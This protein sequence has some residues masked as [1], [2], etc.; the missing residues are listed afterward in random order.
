MRMERWEAVGLVGLFLAGFSTLFFP[1]DQDI[2]GA[3]LAL[4]GLLAIVWGYLHRREMSVQTEGLTPSESW[5]R[6]VT[7]AL[8]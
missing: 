4:L 3:S 6:L 8:Q 5:L 1:F 7:A 2:I